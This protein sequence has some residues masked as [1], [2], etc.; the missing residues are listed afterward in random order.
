MSFPDPTGCGNGTEFTG[1][2]PPSKEAVLDEDGPQ[3]PPASLA[4]EAASERRGGK[5]LKERGWK[6]PNVLV[7]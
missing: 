7:V 1:M 6:R 4:A 2:L 5:M 3:H